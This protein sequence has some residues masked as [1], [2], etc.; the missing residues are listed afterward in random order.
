MSRV[1]LLLCALLVLPA[2]SGCDLNGKPSGMA[3][4]DT[5]EV[6]TKCAPGIQVA[7]DIQH[8]FNE[9]QND[10]RKQEEAIRKLQ[11]DPALN[12]PKSGK[13]DELQRLIN[14]FAQ[15]SQQ[16]RADVGQT[17][18]AKL[19]PVFDKINKVLADYAKAH[20]L[21]AIQ[22]K[23]GFAYVDPSI[24]ITAEIIKQVDQEK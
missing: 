3:V 4:I 18:A 6:V 7:Q 9:R 16:F 8:Q 19:K 14:T 23:K 1:S 17:E 10:L 12:D 15:A 20:G 5:R 11:G 21:A 24:D 2:L 22:D 13:K